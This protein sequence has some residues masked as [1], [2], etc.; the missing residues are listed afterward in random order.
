MIDIVTE[1][2][3]GKT[4][5]ILMDND[6]FFDINVVARQFGRVEEDIMMDIDGA[7]IID[8]ETGTIVTDRGATTIENLS[9]GCK[10]VLNYVFIGKNK[11]EYKKYDTLNISSCGTNALR[12]LF[13]VID[14]AGYNHMKLLLMHNDNLFECGYREYNVDGRRV[15]NLL[16]M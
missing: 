9:T 5:S 14:A 3:Y 10:T 11:E 8:K 4:K 7:T 13:D 6:S 12:K 2:E 15:D 1:Y 16:Y